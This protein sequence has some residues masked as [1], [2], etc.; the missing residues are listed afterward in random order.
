MHVRQV[1]FLLKSI[2]WL[3]DRVYDY[4]LV[5][6]W[7]TVTKLEIVDEIESR[8]RK[9]VV[10]VSG[11]QKD[12]THSVGIRERAH[13]M[14]TLFQSAECC[15]FFAGVRVELKKVASSARGSRVYSLRTEGCECGTTAPA[16]QHSIFVL[17]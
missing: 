11:V 15:H 1:L 13:D 12:I 10:F 4:V 14:Q 9:P 3:N 16:H 7:L 2:W 6:A 17:Q 5:C 8:L